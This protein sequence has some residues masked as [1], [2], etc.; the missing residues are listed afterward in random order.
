MSAAAD[1]VP[2]NDPPLPEDVGWPEPRTRRGV[3]RLLALVRSASTRAPA[4]GEVTRP[5]EEAPPGRGLSSAGQA[6]GLLPLRCPDIPHYEIEGILG[7]GGMG[8]V[9]RA[10]D[11]QNDKVV[12]LK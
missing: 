2:H 3:Q 6:G 5:H 7:E 11:T 10:V 8:V 1:D 4:P 9:Y 12:A